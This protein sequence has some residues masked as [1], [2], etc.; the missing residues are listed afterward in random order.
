MS[1]APESFPAGSTTDLADAE[2]TARRSPYSWFTAGIASWFG[3]M[4]MQQVLFSWIVV[5]ELQ[6]SS[7]WVGIT[8]TSTMIPALFL[9]VVG[10][11]AAD[12][13]DPRRLLIALHLCAAVPVL[14]LATASAL[15][16]VQIP[17]LIAFGLCFGVLSAFAL[18]ARD[19]LLSR[20]AGDDMLRA[21][22]GMTIVQ[23]GA[24][25]AG[26]LTAGLTRFTGSAAMLCVQAGILVIGAWATQQ[27]PAI[28]PSGNPTRGRP[29]LSELGEGIS[30]VARTAELRAPAILVFAV[31]VLF[32][33]PFLVI[34]PLLVRDYYEGGV[35]RL[36]LVL[37]LFPLGTIGG[38]L[39][40]RARGLPRKGRAALLALATGATTLII[41]GLRVPFALLVALTLAWGLA[42][43]VFI[44]SSRTLFQ[45]AAPPDQRGKVL[46]IYQ[47]GFMGGAPIG[48][49]VS[50]FSSASIGLHMTLV[51][52][53]A[54]MLLLVACMALMSALPRME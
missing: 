50:G 15:D 47:L 33:G 28:A 13:F 20:V 8:Q 44:N 4:G 7:E 21:V 9:L 52:F 31:G 19:S 26:T 36:S 38:S 29:S 27:I 24:Q 10:G 34:F 12:R 25:A 30:R 53:G 35:D 17:I 49:L 5:G 14:L 18:P 2:A 40:L 41:I 23:F 1:E 11:A 37:M 6:A 22:A 46:A 39:V 45:Q 32:V 51:G 16:R 54:G 48:A 3:A 42:G 43:S